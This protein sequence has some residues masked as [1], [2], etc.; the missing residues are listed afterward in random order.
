MT[1]P[2]RSELYASRCAVLFMEH[3]GVVVLVNGSVQLVGAADSD[4]GS[5]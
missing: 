5:I 3:A 2:H 4:K 1:R